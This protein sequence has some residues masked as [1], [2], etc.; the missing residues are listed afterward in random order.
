MYVCAAAMLPII[1]YNDM[2]SKTSLSINAKEMFV[3]FMKE[4][5]LIHNFLSD[6]MMVPNRLI[7]TYYILEFD[8]AITQFRLK[9]ITKINVICF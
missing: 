1:I 9:M 3:S 4:S 8:L 5:F 6:R 7:L 2:V